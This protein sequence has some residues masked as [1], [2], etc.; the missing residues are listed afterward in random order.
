MALQVVEPAADRAAASGGGA[1]RADGRGGVHERAHHLA[2][3]RVLP[4]GPALALLHLRVAQDGLQHQGADGAQAV[5]RVGSAS[6]SLITDRAVRP[7]IHQCRARLQSCSFAKNLS[8][9]QGRVKAEQLFELCFHI[10]APVV[11]ICQLLR[12]RDRLSLTCVTVVPGS[13]QRDDRLRAAARRQQTQVQGRP[14]PDG[15][16]RE[17]GVLTNRRILA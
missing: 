12:V 11:R 10:D 16:Q 8:T 6:F 2:A 1:L 14:D 13:Q 4:R 7:K 15:R 17:D 3:R 5:S 9:R